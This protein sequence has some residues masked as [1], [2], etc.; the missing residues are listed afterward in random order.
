MSLNY[1]SIAKTVS[2]ALVSVG[3]PVKFSRAGQ[4]LFKATGIFVASEETNVSSDQL[5]AITMMNTEKKTLL[6]PGT[7][8]AP[9]VGDYVDCKL[10]T[11]CVVEVQAENPAGLPLLYRVVC[12]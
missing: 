8:K 4:S 5:S 11:F 12:Q 3:L 2:M 10:G 1:A 6:I 9:H 7:V